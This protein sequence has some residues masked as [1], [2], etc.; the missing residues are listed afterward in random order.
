MK[1]YLIT[2]IIFKPIRHYLHNKRKKQQSK[3]VNQFILE[4]Q[5][6][7]K[8]ISFKPDLCLYQ[9]YLHFFVFRVSQS[10]SQFQTDIV[11]LW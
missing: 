2:L 8:G 9:I 3:N 6:H 1:L 11:R 4:S 5:E 10:V 7:Q